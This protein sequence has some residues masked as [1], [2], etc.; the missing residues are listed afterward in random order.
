M[1]RSLHAIEMDFDRALRQARQLDEV[2][3]N[4]ENLVSKKMEDTFHVLGQNWT[5]DNSLKYIGKGKQL[6]TKISKTAKDITQ[7]AD[8]IREIARNVY[9]AEMEAWRIA[10]ERD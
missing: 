4:M 8:A 1:A 10:H 6:E 9:E 3:Q 5:G 2:A 7:V